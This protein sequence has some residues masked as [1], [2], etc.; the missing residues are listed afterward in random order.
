MKKE[1]GYPGFL[2]KTCIAI[3]FFISVNLIAQ[4]P[5]IKFNHLTDADGLSQ[6]HAMCA[7]QDSRG[8]MWFGTYAGLNRYDGSNFKIYVSDPKDTT[9][10][11]DN[12]ITNVIEDS[13]GNFWVSS[14]NKGINKYDY[15]TDS[16]KRYQENDRPNSIPNNAINDLFIDKEKQLW[17]ATSNG[18]ARYNY[19]TDDFSSFFYDSANRDGEGSANEDHIYSIEE[20]DDNNLILATGEEELFLFNKITEQYKKLAY[21]PETD[22]KQGLVEKVLLMD[23]N[24]VLWIGSVNKGLHS[25]DYKTKKVKSYSGVGSKPYVNSLSI[26]SLLIDQNSNLWVGSDGQGLYIMNPQRTEVKNFRTDAFDPTTLGSN[27]GIYDIFEDQN[28]I[29]WLAQYNAGINYYDKNEKDFST[30]RNNPNDPGSLSANIIFS[31]LEDSEGNIW[32]G[33]DGGGLNKFN[34]L[35]KKFIHY[36]H[37]PSNKKSLQSNIIK[38]IAED[39]S[40]N[41]LLG[42][43][44]AGLM[45]FNKNT[46]TSVQYRHDPDNPNTLSDDDVWDIEVDKLGKVWL[47]TLG[48]GLDRFIPE[49]GRFEH[50]GP[51]TDRPNKSNG[52]DIRTIYQDENGIIW[53]GTLLNGVNRLDPEKEQFTYLVNDPK[54]NNSLAKND[55]RA[56]F[57]DRDG[58]MWF[59]TEGSGLDRYD[60]KSKTFTN[61]SIRDGL[62][63]NIIHGILQDDEGLL[64]ISTG[65]GLATFN[66][67]TKK[68]RIYN[69]FDGLQGDDFQ[70]GADMKTKDGTMYFGGLNGFNV[71]HPGNIKDNLHIPNVVFTKLS[72]LYKE[73]TL[74]S[75][76]A[77]L[78]L[79][80]EET[81]SI[82]LNYDQNVIAFEFAT[83]NYTNSDKNMYAYQMEG[84]DKDWNY[85]GSEH[86]ATYTN[87]DPGE[88]TFRVKG[89]NNDGI[90]NETGAS[91]NIIITPPFWA[92]WWFRSLMAMLIIYTAYFSYKTRIRIIKRQKEEL[93]VQVTERTKELNERN[94]DLVISKKQTDDILNNVKDGLFLINK[95]FKIGSQYSKSLE[96]IL[97]EDNPGNKS[98]IEYFENKIKK[99]DLKNT[100][101][102]LELLF[103][104]KIDFDAIA[105]LNPLSQIEFNYEDKENDRKI[106]KFLTFNFGRITENGHTEHIIATV[107][108]ITEKIQLEKDLKESQEESKRKME[109]LLKILN[110]EPAMLHDFIKNAQEEIDNID[111]V[112]TETD[113]AEWSKELLTKIGRYVHTIKGNAGL[114]DLDFLAQKAHQVEDEIA[115]LKSRQHISRKNTKKLFN[116]IQVVRDSYYEIKELIDQIGKLNDQM[117]S[118]KSYD[119]EMLPKFLSKLV[120]RLAKEHDKKVKLIMD[121]Y[122][123]DDIPAENRSL[124]SDVLVQLVRNSMAHGIESCPLRKKA[125]KEETGKIEISNHVKGDVYV[126][127]FK[128]DGRGIQLEKLR[129]KA[130]ETGKWSA[131][132]VNN[133]DETTLANI[134]FMPHLTTSDEAGMTSGRGMGM[135]IVKSKVEKMNGRIKI[136]TKK[137]QFCQFTIEFKKVA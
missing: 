77:I 87:L 34:P 32:V 112:I 120:N 71:F 118:Q 44:N 99:D 42:T 12:W 74:N 124:I 38:S 91:I 1:F 4:L 20:D 31:F 102:Y 46:G 33:T 122:K 137:D 93:E 125:G 67:E 86:N 54:N 104:D 39:K 134:I 52:D 94:Q 6:N 101:D 36:K 62:P 100:K 90:W 45:V 97:E 131:D 58:I 135:D 55:V 50:Y 103:D 41:L 133:W 19:E 49:E 9:T 26:R 60:E 136:D 68:I 115:D 3:Y 75:P 78:K 13:Y 105:E 11:T 106:I 128:D 48:G 98:L 114:L 28:G 65:K 73:V 108:D 40:G 121:N 127:H 82:T 10:L 116:L 63:S 117:R 107:N 95:E 51:L 92:T 72:V 83:L 76:D 66:L 16:F 43:W 80:I 132:E 53:I 21:L 17:I 56:I 130:I 61:F 70:Y 25:I 47:G 64:W 89:S 15:K 109:W 24:G 8:Y 18:L 110:I 2:T 27:N 23:S 119:S 113:R 111:H 69:K 96:K 88:Y 57:R 123:G 129:R 22:K 35:T 85:A 81:K 29:I 126:I 79:P 59:G 30:M 37:N 7:Y 14:L 84:F 5:D